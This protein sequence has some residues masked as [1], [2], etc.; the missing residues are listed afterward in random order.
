MARGFHI[1]LAQ[2]DHGCLA[3]H[4]SATRARDDVRSGRR[5]ARS[6][7]PAE[8][9][10]RHVLGSPPTLATTSGGRITMPY[11]HILY[12]VGDKIATITLNRPDRMNAWTAVMEHEMMVSLRSEDFREGVASLVEMRAPR[13]TGR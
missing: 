13:F 12:E 2:P 7:C 4:V 1:G 5:I 6:F 11:Q 8:T 9:S 3:N 10:P